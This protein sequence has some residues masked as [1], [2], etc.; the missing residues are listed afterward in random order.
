MPP[1]TTG[2]QVNILLLPQNN[3]QWIK[4][5]LWFKFGPFFHFF[6][7][8]APCTLRVWLSVNI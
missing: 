1:R 6:K 4:L 2:D 3:L 5:S 7:T 8:F